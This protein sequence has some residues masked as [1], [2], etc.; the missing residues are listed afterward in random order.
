MTMEKNQIL[1][2][3][4]LL[5]ILYCTLPLYLNSNSS[6]VRWFLCLQVSI[7]LYQPVQGKK[8]ASASS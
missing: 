4:F 6:M 2:I 7:A 1:I 3:S 5:S 8:L